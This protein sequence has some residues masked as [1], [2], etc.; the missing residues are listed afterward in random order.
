MASRHDTP[1]P[2]TRDGPVTDDRARSDASSGEKRAEPVVDYRGTGIMWTAVALVVAIAMFVIIALQNM[3]DVEFDFLWFDAAIP[4]SLIL[5]IT[6]ATA[7]V[8]GEV[9]GFVWRRRR[10]NRLRERDEL[11]RLRSGSG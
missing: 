2:L 5:A 6:F 10:R 8:V 4:L 9:T 11:R 3:R 1:A 7:L